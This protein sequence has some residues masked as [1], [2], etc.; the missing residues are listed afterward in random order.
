[1]CFKGGRMGCL[2]TFENALLFDLE[3]R[4]WFLLFDGS[5]CG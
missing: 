3:L 5:M 1:M 4:L 2:L